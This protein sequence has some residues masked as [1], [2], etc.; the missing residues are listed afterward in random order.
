MRKQDNKAPRTLAERTD[1]EIL[2]AYAVHKTTRKAAAAIGCGS[3][4]FKDRLRKISSGSSRA[5][6]SP[7]HR[8]PLPFSEEVLVAAERATRD[9]AKSGN[10][11]RHLSQYSDY[12]LIQ[13][14]EDHDQDYAACAQL[15][16]CGPLTFEMRIFLLTDAE[17]IQEKRRAVKSGE[18]SAF[19]VEELEARGTD[20]RTQD[21]VESTIGNKKNR[22][23]STYGAGNITPLKGDGRQ[24]SIRYRP[25]KSGPVGSPYMLVESPAAQPISYRSLPDMST[26]NGVRKFVWGDTQIGFYFANG[27]YTPFHD[28]AAISVSLQMLAWFKP[29]EVVFNGDLADYEGLSKWLQ[30]PEF[31]GMFNRTNRTC[32]LLLR[33]VRT[34]VGPKC[35][36]FFVKGNHERRLAEY[37][38]THCKA[39]YGAKPGW[40]G[41]DSQSVLTFEYLVG[42]HIL[43]IEASATYPG[44]EHWLSRNPRSPV[45]C[46]HQGAVRAIEKMRATIVCGHW[47]ERKISSSTY[48]DFEG[49]HEREVIVVPGVG[50]P[51]DVKNPEQLSRTHAP[52]NTTRKNL[53]QTQGAFTF[54]ED[55]TWDFSYGRIKDGVGTFMGKRFE[56]DPNFRLDPYG[57]DESAA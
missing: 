6:F 21:I 11:R 53:Q 38:V 13:L 55:G 50:N 25:K 48:H 33:E 9:T 51:H 39:L 29:H 15:V 35:K 54:F 18:I 26:T 28:V 1:S 44:G 31:E 16:G 52:S 14:Y 17:Y 4:T 32:Y 46:T 23:E 22:W 42:F 10:E 57:E 49:T 3:S 12:E 41:R 36:I 5:E 20:F 24:A 37:I 34:I 47:E 19:D 2:E 43:D 7:R 27:V 8:K 56:A 45:V 40:A 30:I